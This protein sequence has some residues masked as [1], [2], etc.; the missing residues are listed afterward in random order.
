MET[1]MVSFGLLFNL[2]VPQTVL[3][4]LVDIGIQMT[5]KSQI[6]MTDA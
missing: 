6:L 1:L 2:Q 4:L 5:R 3:E